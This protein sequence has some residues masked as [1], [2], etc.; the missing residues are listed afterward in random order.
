MGGAVAT[1]LAHPALPL[2]DQVDLWRLEATRCLDPKRRSE[3]GQ[4]LT[5]SPVA[6]FMAS[7][8]ESFPTEVRLLDAGAGAGALLVAVTLEALDREKVPQRIAVTGYEI[9]PTL[10]SFLKQSTNALGAACAR[11]GVTFNAEA[12]EGDF[13]KAAVELVDQGLFRRRSDPGFTH[14]I[15]NPPYHKLNSDSVARL[16][17]RR[18]GIE[19]S[20]LYTA[21]VALAIQRLAPGGELVAIT[22]RSFCN[23]PYFRPFR[24]FMLSATAVR[25]IHLFESRTAAFSDD[26]VLQENVIFH[27]VKGA[28]QHAVTVS[29]SSSPDD[30]LLSVREVPFA[31]IVRPGDKDLFIHLVPD[32]GGQRLS[33]AFASLPCKLPELGLTVSTGKVVDFRAKD[34]LRAGPEAGTG[35][36]IYP[37]HFAE[38]RV[39]WPKAGKKPNAL[40]RAAETSALW[41]PAGVYVLVKR[42]S[43]KEEPRR[44][45]AAVFDPADVPGDQIG[46]ENH[47]NVFHADG[48]GCDPK[49]AR[50]LSAFLNSTVVDTYFRQFN[51]HT[52]VN[53]T[54]LRNLR[55]PSRAA[56]VELGARLGAG[57]STEQE[58]DQIVSDVV[59]LALMDDPGRTQKIHEALEVLKDLG[60]PRQQ[61]ND[62]SALT[63]LAL[64]GL[65]PE[66]PW[67]KAAAP[68]M[69]ITPIMDFAKD[70]YGKAYA[71]NTRET[72]RRQTVHQFRDAGLILANP[73]DPARAVN[74]PKAVYQIEA[75]ARELLRTFG[76]KAWKTKLPAYV[77]TA[78]TLAG[79]CAQAREMA[80]LP[81]T[82]ADG[83]VLKLTPGGQNELVKKIVE[84]FCPTFAPGG[85]LIYVGDTGDKFALFDKAGLK[86]LGVEM[87]SHGK[88][89][90]LVVHRTDKNWLLLIEAVTSHGP[91]NPKR[92]AE[93]A[94]LFSKSTAGLVYVTAFLTRKEML[95]YLGDISWETEVWVAE[96]PDHM[97]HFDGERFLGPYAK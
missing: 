77:A 37:T 96:S 4:F 92:L 33:D 16:L 97:I 36:L 26:E 38:G 46:F 83:H 14:A 95:K 66:T 74:S 6:S 32:E 35:P 88:M 53:A 60:L 40:V 52:Q 90:D 86:A 51:G 69:G 50:G 45:V 27:L 81:V 8:F 20:N 2:L 9:D 58:L 3:F 55:Y 93:L 34:F 54:D 94:H 12:V 68:L 22:P 30:D 67:S 5:P 72:V 44:V 75:K 29:S 49:L 91:V 73:D 31:Q 84:D 70:H 28:K 17:L 61:Q 62:R 76:S 80:R 71:P 87:D 47:L 79:R 78:G 63:L 41:M 19:T 56:L 11:Q 10:A 82:L 15:L 24:E 7:L 23:G 85:R 65:K 39:Q 48:A 21:F 57:P 13:I 89:P 43:S 64:L 42:F 59:G 1:I 25:R 18:A